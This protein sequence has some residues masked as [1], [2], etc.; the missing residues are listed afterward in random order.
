MNS[1]V[2]QE[3]EKIACPEPPLT[4]TVSMVWH[5]IQHVSK[6]LPNSHRGDGGSAAPTTH[7][8]FD[9]LECLRRQHH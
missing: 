4:V 3:P 1:V 9:G 2:A 7:W 5:P 8:L 6:P